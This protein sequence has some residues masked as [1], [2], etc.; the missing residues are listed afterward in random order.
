M[1]SNLGPPPNLDV[2]LRPPTWTVTVRDV[3]RSSML[4]VRGM[5]YDDDPRSLMPRLRWARQ[6]WAMVAPSVAGGVY[7]VRYWTVWV[8]LCLG[9]TAWTWT[10]WVERRP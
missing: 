3:M 5:G 7:K 10:R 8:T 2:P 4:G 6:S 9:G 1:S